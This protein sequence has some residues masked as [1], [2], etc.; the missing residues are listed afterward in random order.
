MGLND[1]R[2]SSLA[3]TEIYKK[4][5]LRAV[6][7]AGHIEGELPQKNA[8]SQNGVV[9]ILDLAAEQYTLVKQTFLVP[10]LTACG[11]QAEQT[12]EINISTAPQNYEQIMQEYAPKLVIFFGVLPESLGF[13]LNFP[14]QKQQKFA[15]TM[16]YSTYGAAEIMQEPAKKK[17]FWNGLKSYFG[18]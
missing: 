2:F 12:A 18:L 10:F 15:E 3:I 8:G 6:S 13:P 11:L 17:D 9:L 4:H 14:M 7:P 16:L 1:I 5:L